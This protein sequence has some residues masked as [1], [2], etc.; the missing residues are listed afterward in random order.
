M[1]GTESTGCLINADKETKNAATE[2]T[3]SQKDGFLESSV[4]TMGLK[5]KVIATNPT[6][7]RGLPARIVPRTIGIIPA[8]RT[9][10]KKS[11]EFT[12]A[13]IIRRDGT[14]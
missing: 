8:Q 2:V 14:P 1:E 4:G 12:K 13:P 9:I 11:S 10:S 7:H 5:T 3:F 6:A